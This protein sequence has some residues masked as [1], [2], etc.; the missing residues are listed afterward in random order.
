MIKNLYSKSAI[1][2]KSSN[3]YKNVKTNGYS[4]KL[5][6]EYSR[7]LLLL[8]KQKLINDYLE[9]VSISLNVNDIQV[10]KIIMD[11]VIIEN[12]GTY[13]YQDT[14]GVLTQGQR[15]KYKLFKAIKPNVKFSIVKR[16]RKGF[17]ELPVIIKNK[18]ISFKKQ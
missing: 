14:K 3:K 15:T 12:D 13:H 4:S 11:F 18:K 17:V 16:T 8:K 1:I 7:H 10:C 2:S 6:Y 5:E 9:Q